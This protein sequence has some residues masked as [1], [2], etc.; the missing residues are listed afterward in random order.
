MLGPIVFRYLPL[1]NGRHWL[2]LKGLLVR[3]LFYRPINKLFQGQGSL[4]KT[5]NSILPN[6]GLSLINL[7]IVYSLTALNIL[8]TLPLMINICSFKIQYHF[9]FFLH[10]S[11]DFT[12]TTA[13]KFVNKLIYK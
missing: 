2:G 4:I 3:I 6:I 1:R 13:R 10:F 12:F 7:T 11:A 5:I 8:H 9:H